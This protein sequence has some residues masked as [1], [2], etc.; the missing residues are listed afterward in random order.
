M[1]YDRIDY[2]LMLHQDVQASYGDVHFYDYEE[3]AERCYLRFISNSTLYIAERLKRGNTVNFYK[4]DRSV[5]Y[6]R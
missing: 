4:L 5:N 3:S 1:S 6:D 2:K